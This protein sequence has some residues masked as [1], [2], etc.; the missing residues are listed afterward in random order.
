MTFDSNIYHKSLKQ[1]EWQLLDM[2]IFHISDF[3]CFI[4]RISKLPC[5]FVTISWPFIC[6]S[7]QTTTWQTLHFVYFQLQTQFTLNTIAWQT[8]TGGHILT[9]F[10]GNKLDN[11]E[12]NVSFVLA[13][14][15]NHWLCYGLLN[16]L[17]PW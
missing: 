4:L 10:N 9:N 5:V 7:L 8:F 1:L 3:V 17:C 16:K 11:P 2:N 13:V 6:L 14:V 12:Q 15:T